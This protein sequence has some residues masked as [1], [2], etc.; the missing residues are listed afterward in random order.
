MSKKIEGK[1]LAESFDSLSTITE[2]KPIGSSKPESISKEGTE[3]G[4]EFDEA[5]GTII[6][7]AKNVKVS[8]DGNS[9]KPKD[10]KSNVPI[11]D[12]EVVGPIK[13]NEGKGLKGIMVL[14]TKN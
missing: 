11:Q 13:G 5:T 12:N 14:N 7:K 6:K 2:V 3:S 9:Q 4:V 8:G 10:L 1:T